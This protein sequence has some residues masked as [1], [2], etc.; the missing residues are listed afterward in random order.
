MFRTCRNSEFATI[1]STH[2]DGKSAAN[3]LRARDEEFTPHHRRRHRRG[4]GL[5]RH[6]SGNRTRGIRKSGRPNSDRHTDAAGVRTGR[7]D[8]GPGDRDCAWHAPARPRGRRRACR[9]QPE[10]VRRRL[11]SCAAAGGDVFLVRARHRH[12]LAQPEC[13]HPAAAVRGSP[14]RGR[15][16]AGGRATKSRSNCRPIR[17]GCRASHGS[18]SFAATATGR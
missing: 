4:G 8:R 13:R 2:R 11:S 15:R 7:R 6:V 12:A 10:G 5:P 18:T 9:Q 16:A 14:S 1:P 17:T 3:E